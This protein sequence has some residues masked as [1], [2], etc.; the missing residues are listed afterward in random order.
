MAGL[1]RRTIAARA[2]CLLLSGLS[3]M[4]AAKA[5]ETSRDVTNL[6]ARDIVRKVA[7]GQLD[8]CR[9]AE[10]FLSVIAADNHNG[11]ISTRRADEFDVCKGPHGSTDLQAKRLAGLPI[12][13]KDNILV[14]GQRATFGTSATKDYFA[15]ET[16]DAV[17]RLMDQGA[18]V[19]GKLNLHELAGGV[20]SNNAVY[21]PV[22]NAYDP[23][24]FAGG[25]SGGA[26]AAVGARLVPV[27]LGTDTG[28]S[29]LIP[30]AL[31]GAIGFRPTVGRYPMGGVLPVSPT[32]DTIGPIARTVEDIIL[33]DSVMARS[34]SVIRPLDLRDLRVGIP[35]K[36]FVDVADT[37]SR[38]KFDHVLE[39]LKAA[40]MEIVAVDL[41][42]LVQ[43]EKGF[44]PI[45][46]YE[47]KTE[48]PKFLALH[49]VGISFDQLVAGIRS[50][51]LIKDYQT[52]FLGAASPDEEAYKTALQTFKP[53][54]ENVFRSAFADHRLIALALPTTLTDARPIEGSDDQIAMD[55]KLI[56][57]WKAY[58]NNTN[59]ITKGSLAALSLPMGLSSRGL[60][61]GVTFAVLPGHD[62]DV[63]SLGL[64]VQALLPVLPAPP[65]AAD[66]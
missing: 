52:R 1:N 17:Q 21:G 28:G 60:P 49:K 20:T 29:V 42:D 10:I 59:Y 43:A 38:T 44:G 18:I 14:A 22:R 33:V 57:T 24:C 53:A 19:I 31:N 64:S 13:V 56:P 8:P 51:D 47:L 11:F 16:A 25:S 62:E 32:R 6:S 12:A 30:A 65:I 2:G 4:A 5:A 37:D 61:L 63:L 7:A 58:I 50:P 41:P 9:A 66:Q 55:G 27:A 36:L 45:T 39:M 3:I 34:S 54:V 26:G 48:V 35:R 15:T 46:P 23:R 40:G